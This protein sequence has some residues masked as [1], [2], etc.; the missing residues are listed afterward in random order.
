M[1]VRDLTD[2]VRATEDGSAVPGADVLIVGAS[3]RAAA[4]SAIRAGLAPFAV[5]QFGDTD[6][7]LVCPAIL[8]QEYPCD[9][10]DHFSMI[11]A[12]LPWMYTGALEN[13][14]DLIERLAAMRALWGN[15]ANVVRQVRDPWQLHATLSAADIAIPAV[16]SLA[17][18]P[19]TKGR[20][21]VKS[22]H[23]SGGNGVR[24][25]SSP[26]TIAVKEPAY[27]QQF[28]DGKPTSAVF[29]A[30]G[31]RSRLLG[32][33]EQLIGTT[34]AGADGYRYVGSL[35]TTNVSSQ[36]TAQFDRI[37]GA[38]AAS[39][40][41]AGLFGVDAIESNGL[42]WPVEVN[43]RYTASI[44]VIERQRGIAAIDLHVQACRNGALPAI[45]PFM[46]DTPLC[47]GKV[48]LFARRDVT[49]SDALIERV[50]ALNADTKWPTVADIPQ[51]GTPIQRGAP[52]LTVL[53]QTTDVSS[54][55]EQLQ[56]TVGELESL[57][58]SQS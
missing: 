3:A 9:V 38:L 36:I 51:P 28:I 16:R 48:I 52:I 37:G 42:I 22:P 5:D 40:G 11:D 21:L 4:H 1:K 56:S 19:P 53:V 43:P 46:P 58:S 25:W 44:E 31:G 45:D 32:A 14:P 27:L 39:F 18:A 23:N 7:R 35:A 26:E 33:S 47:V 6:L 15:D 24:D 29:V 17:D 55:Q 8:V 20:W 12:A 41:L 49:V 54:A 30:A 10:V 13:Y 57:L 2:A 50:T 34:W